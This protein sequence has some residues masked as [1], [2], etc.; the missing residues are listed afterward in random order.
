MLSCG[1]AEFASDSALTIG[2]LPK[3]DPAGI[4]ARFPQFAFCS[5]TKAYTS[6]SA[7]GGGHS[8]TLPSIKVTA[9]S[10]GSAA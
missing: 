8:S 6:H 7:G 4:E 10:K 9:L 3:L 5:D 2:A 1:K